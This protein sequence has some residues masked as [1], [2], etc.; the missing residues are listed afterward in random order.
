MQVVCR[1]GC[2]SVLITDQ[3]REFVN[4]LSAQLYAV[5][6]TEHRITS[7]YHPQVNIVYSPL[8]T[9]NIP[10][11][12]FKT[13]HGLTERFN[14][15]LSR[16]LAKVIDDDQCNWE[17]KI[18]RDIVHLDKHQQSTRRILCFTNKI[19]DY[20]LMLSFYHSMQIKVK[21][22]WILILLWMTF[23]YLGKRLFSK[24][25]CNIDEAQK[26]QK[27]TYD[28]KHL[29]E[30]LPIGTEVLLENTADKQ[31]KGGKLN[32]AWRGPY[33]ICKAYGKGVYQLCN[34]SGSEI[35]NKV[36]VNRL[37]LYKKRRSTTSEEEV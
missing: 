35:R 19:W 16:C 10:I 18:D 7:A 11:I 26:K 20:P 13:N 34:Q 32:P 5:T 4:E 23:L 27:E 9:I 1:H 8:A 17:E 3:G 21:T 33:T 29:P 36:N 14:Q 25:K 15:T 28:R 24:A 37:K 30:E 22:V 2:P 12:F 6:N 31:R